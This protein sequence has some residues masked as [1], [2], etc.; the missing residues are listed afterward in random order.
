[1]DQSVTS[2]TTLRVSDPQQQTR[3]CRVGPAG[4]LIGRSSAVQ[5][6]LEG[7]GVSRRHASLESTPQGWSIRDLNSR[8]GTRINGQPI[9]QHT[10]QPGDVI[11]ISSYRLWLVG[12]PAEAPTGCQSTLAPS[13]MLD[14]S[15][16]AFSRLHE[17]A[18]PRI[19]AAHLR[20]IQ[21]LGRS[22]LNLPDR[23][24]RVLKLCESL[25][26]SAFRGTYAAVVTVSSQ[27]AH[28]RW[29]TPT[30]RCGPLST[31]PARFPVDDGG[32]RLSRS[33]LE[34]AVKSDEAVL[35][36]GVEHSAGPMRENDPAV[37]ALSIAPEAD[38]AA[39][40]ACPLPTTPDPA[41]GSSNEAAADRETTRDVL[42]IMLP[43]EYGTSE[44]L[45][46]TALAVEQHEFV[47]Q[48][49]AGRQAAEARARIEQ[50]IDRARQVQMGL[51]PAV[52]SVAGLELT[53]HY[54]PCL[55][56]GGDYIDL[57]PL[58]GDK[59]LLTVMDVCGKSMQAALISS[60]LH[61]FLHSH[62]EAWAD[63]P[64]ETALPNLMNALNRYLCR[65]LPDHS[66][67]TAIALVLDP[68]TGQ[69]HSVNAGHPPT[70]I[71]APDRATRLLETGGNVPLGLLDDPLHSTADRLE[72]GETLMLYTDGLTEISDQESGQWISH[73][74]LADRLG[75]LIANDQPLTH[76][77]DRL[78]ADLLDLYQGQHP[79][80]DMTFLLAR[81]ESNQR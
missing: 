27:I 16:S 17:M 8:N 9:T 72:P 61:T 62:V 12:Q 31:D 76:L 54:E 70:L 7:D 48:A 71:A 28:G 65:S 57:I 26:G 81:R 38:S 25:I 60:S 67:V 33:L 18:A 63:R 74:G 77:R 80:D 45:A 14:N 22:L 10:L 3:D 51:V 64:A 29:S 39:V 13:A 56:V 35:A 43:E 40:I 42:Y 49:W 2:T 36:T 20:A 69:M 58:A 46:L 21:A 47:E 37:V 59:L 23:P 1:M 75:E 79:D 52:P 30:L 11:E 34:A 44:W 6:V 24:A 32:F 73:D 19:D 55:G 15:P 78:M 41:S 4:L 53:L 50:D 66:F 5:L 68:A